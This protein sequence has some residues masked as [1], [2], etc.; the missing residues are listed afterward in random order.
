MGPKLGVFRVLVRLFWTA[1]DLEAKLLNF[2][3]YYMEHIAFAI[4]NKRFAS[5]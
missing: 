1:T 3:H 4:D 2:Q 5:E